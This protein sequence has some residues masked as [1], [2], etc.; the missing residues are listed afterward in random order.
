MEPRLPFVAFAARLRQA[1]VKVEKVHV[2]V[3][4]LTISQKSS[5][6]NPT[7]RASGR[8]WNRAIAS[9]RIL[10]GADR[11]VS[12]RLARFRALARWSRHFVPIRMAVINEEDLEPLLRR[13]T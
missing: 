11:V 5:E 1:A 8:H 7:A 12:A 13:T 9:N 2:D 10:A 4:E 6:M 3:A